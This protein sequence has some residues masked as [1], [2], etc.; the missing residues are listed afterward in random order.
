LKR[1]V[2]KAVLAIICQKIDAETVIVPFEARVVEEGV[3]NVIPFMLSIGVPMRENRVFILKLHNF[4]E[5]CDTN[6]EH[7]D[8]RG[9]KN[10]ETNEAGN[11]TNGAR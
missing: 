11:I 3:S 2:P 7:R 6:F 1:D 5:A 8:E 9:I 4:T 10:G